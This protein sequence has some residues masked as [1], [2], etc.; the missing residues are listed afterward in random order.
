MAFRKQWMQ[1]R[2]FVHYLLNEEFASL[3]CTFIMEILFWSNV[4][5][6]L[7]TW[8]SICVQIYVEIW[9]FSLLRLMAVGNHVFVDY[10]FLVFLHIAKWLVQNSILWESLLGL[11]S[12]ILWLTLSNIDYVAKHTVHCACDEF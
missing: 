5:E 9:F 12:I 8:P 3:F 1:L 11:A 6:V 4:L 7:K 10:L 2:I